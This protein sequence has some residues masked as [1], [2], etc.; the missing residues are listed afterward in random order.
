[1][2][3]GLQRDVHRGADSPLTRL[4]KSDDFRMWAAEPLVMTGAND[5]AVVDDDGT[6]QGVGL[7][8]ASA[9]RGQLQRSPHPVFVFALGH[10]CAT[11][12]SWAQ[13]GETPVLDG[14]F[15]ARSRRAGRRVDRRGSA[16]RAG[17]DGRWPAG[18][19]I[20]SGCG[21]TSR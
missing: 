9:S 7:N 20:S 4:L 16:T 11:S 6:D 15:A 5:R 3:A 12:R 18:G 8:P 17:A 1:M 21:N 10:V 19:L 2:A 14:G 13:K